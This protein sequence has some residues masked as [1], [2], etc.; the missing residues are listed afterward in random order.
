MS[1]LAIALCISSMR[2]MQTKEITKKMKAGTPNYSR[3]DYKG[4]SAG[5]TYLEAHGRHE[6]HD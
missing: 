1:M 6:E 4:H 3:Q 5:A 2:L